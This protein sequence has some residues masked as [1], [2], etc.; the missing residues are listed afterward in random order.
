MR[1]LTGTRARAREKFHKR[2]KKV[3][4][5]YVV[6]DRMRYSLHED[7]PQTNWICVLKKKKVWNRET[8]LQQVSLHI[9][10]SMVCQCFFSLDVL[11]VCGKIFARLSRSQT[12]CDSFCSF[13]WLRGNWIGSEISAKQEH[14]NS[15]WGSAECKDFS[16]LYCPQSLQVVFQNK[17]ALKFPSALKILVR[18][19]YFSVIITGTKITTKWSENDEWDPGH[20]KKTIWFSL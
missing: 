3:Q 19:F 17:A 11:F 1:N 12:H 4:L 5:S 15:E 18:M 10:A 13:N 20:T 7:K 8:Y 6:V 2:H 9:Y 14:E 16:P